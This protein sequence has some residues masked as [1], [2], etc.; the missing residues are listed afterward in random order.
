MA[1]RESAT[2]DAIKRHL[3]RA[4]GAYVNKTHGDATKA[5]RLDIEACVRGLFVAVEVKAPGGSHPLSRRQAAEIVRIQRAGG[6]AFTA[7]SVDDVD[8]QL[9]GKV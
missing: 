5:G 2:V 1:P 9:K 6:I 8:T 7:T 4:Y 3:K